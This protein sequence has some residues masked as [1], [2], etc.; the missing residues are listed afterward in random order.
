MFHLIHLDEPYGHMRHYVGSAPKW[1]KRALAAGRTWRVARTWGEKDRDVARLLRGQH[2]GLARF[3]PICSG[4]VAQ[5]RG[6]SM[7]RPPN[8]PGRT[9]VRAGEEKDFCLRCPLRDCVGIKSSRC[10]ITIETRR[11]ERAYYKAR[12]AA[13]KSTK[14]SGSGN[15]RR[16]SN[17]Q[18]PEW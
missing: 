18:P 4:E 14:A 15:S 12:R 13:A 16:P 5:K 9:A 7:G 6:L 17:D 2:H 3:C 10:P 11:R 8:D 1:L